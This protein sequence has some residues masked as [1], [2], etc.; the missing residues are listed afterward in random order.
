MP[1]LKIKAGWI[2]RDFRFWYS[3][4]TSGSVWPIVL[5]NQQLG[6]S[7]SALLIA[8]YAMPSTSIKPF[9]FSSLAKTGQNIGRD[10]VSEASFHIIK[11]KKSLFI[12]Q[13][14]L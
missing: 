14:D 11:N 9:Y 1:R 2:F 7:S 4:C 5:T 10:G 12:R 13:S 8:C 3:F 6:N